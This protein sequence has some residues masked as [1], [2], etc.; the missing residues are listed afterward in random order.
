[1]TSP[2]Q[3]VTTIER[4][5]LDVTRQALTAVQ[6][7][8]DKYLVFPSDEARDAVVL[9]TMHTYVFD[10][11]GSTPRLSVRSTEPGSGKSRV[12][13]LIAELAPRAV[14]AVYLEPAVMWRV[15]NAGAP[16]LLL[17]ECDTVFGKAGSG[18][19]HVGL[20]SIIN[21]GHR[22]GST[23]PRCVGS[24]DVKEF[25][26][27][28]PVALAGIG[29]LPDTIATRSVE[30]V[31]RKRRD[32]DPAVK[33]FRLKLAGDSLKVTAGLLGFWS[34]RAAGP[35]SVAMPDLPVADRAAD[36]WEPLVAIADLAGPEWATRARAAC[37]RLVAEASN[38]PVASVGVR[39]LTDIRTVFDVDVLV[40]AE[41]IQRLYAVPDGS[42]GGAQFTSRQMARVLAEYDVKATTARVAGT[43]CRAYLRDAFTAAWDMYLPA[44]PVQAD[45]VV[46]PETVNVG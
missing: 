36:V 40:P 18:T 44:V 9:W 12:L 35:L 14:S 16:T 7:E 42:W 23:V 45:E 25:R 27:F 4:P 28:S 39:L 2:V 22:A 32:C 46:G 19:S 15:I 8:F 34:T 1:M 11:F 21:A 5:L 24:E 37:T 33:P 29:R 26:V 31:M 41:L 38:R 3:T 10:Q 17:D 43:P 6:G 30:I 13:E 20:R